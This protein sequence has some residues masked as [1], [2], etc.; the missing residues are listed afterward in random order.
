[1]KN[2]NGLLGL[3]AVGA[4]GVLGFV[5]DKLFKGEIECPSK[6]NDTLED[7]EN[8]DKPRMQ[9]ITEEAEHIKEDE[10]IIEEK[11]ESK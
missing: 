4:A 2:V 10:V 5:G 6:K 7:N 3:I 11:T 8:D 1:M 9:D